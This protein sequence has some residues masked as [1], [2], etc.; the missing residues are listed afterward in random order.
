MILAIDDGDLDVDDRILGQHALL[1][2]VLDAALDGGQVGTRDGRAAQLV[3]KDEPAARGK[4]LHLD[5]DVGELAVTAGLLDQAP[6]AVHGP[7]DR[8]AV[9]HLWRA[10]V[11]LNLE[12]ALEPVDD[13]LEVQLAH[14]GEHGLA[15]LYVLAHAQ[16]RI[17]LYE[18]V[19]RCA[20]PGLVAARGRR[21]GQLD[22]RRREG[23]AL[24]HDG[25]GR[26]GEGLSGRG[27]VEAQH[28][29]DV[30]GPD[31]FDLFT[32]VGVHADQTPDALVVSS[33][34]VDEHLPAADDATV[35]ADV[36]QAPDVRV[37]G[38]LE[39][40]GG[41]G[42]I[43][44]GQT[45]HRTFG[46]RVEPA[47]GLPVERRRQKVEHGVEQQL[48]A[49]VLERR[50]SQD[51]EQCP[52]QG[53]LAQRGADLLGR[54]RLLLQI[55][56]GHVVVDVGQAHDQIL[57]TPGGR[58]GQLGRDLGHDLLCAVA[59]VVADGAHLDQVDQAT[60]LGFL[61]DGH[62]DR[63]SHGVEAI[64]DG[65]DSPPKV[66]ADAV[67]LVDEADARHGETVGL[68]P[69][70]FGLRLDAGDGVKD[71]DA[72]V[73]DAQRTLHLGGKVDVAGRVD[74]VDLVAVPFAGDGGGL[75][76]DAALALLRHIVGHRGAVVDVAQAV[77]APGVKEHTLGGG[78]L[79]RIDVG[80]NAYISCFEQIVSGC[81]VP[82][83]SHT[84]RPPHL[85]RHPVI[86]QMRPPRYRSKR[87]AVRDSRLS[88]NGSY[89][90]MECGIVKCDLARQAR[91]T[92]AAGAGRGGA[93]FARAGVPC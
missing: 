60:E 43:G 18:A 69:D 20:Y 84:K 41:G 7:G 45:H 61:A 70:R 29:A 8:L 37:G 10:D 15:G 17:L 33:A 76:G 46:L 5:L 1:H 67:H 90:T 71:D 83:A 93:T 24:E 56:V 34:R 40:E 3:L 22:H 72:P 49:L 2:G 57:A 81:H 65:L 31:L 79:A 44:V 9:G 53:G 16:G 86:V 42:R 54:N 21:D 68:S 14:A 85:A 12:L 38:D 73:E 27:D 62:L 66:G 63:D 64:T 77:R 13:D 78:G 91:G 48:D 58:A 32:V 51:G 92:A 74:Q 30:T 82:Y 55:E 47:H 36:G 25:A 80:D 52:A 11:G 23:D 75:D 35:D 39:D 19:Q 28:G 59:I 89:Y 4:G 26:I 6:D 88:S 87:G 50:T